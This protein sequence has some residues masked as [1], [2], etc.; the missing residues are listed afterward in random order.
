MKGYGGAPLFDA[1][2]EGPVQGWRERAKALR[3]SLS[4][5]SGRQLDG[6]DLALLNLFARELL[7]RLLRKKQVGARRELLS[8]DAEERDE[9]ADRSGAQC[10]ARSP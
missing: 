3:Q 8:R 2:E 10:R 5:R 6:L 9:Q 1:L 4:P 7:F